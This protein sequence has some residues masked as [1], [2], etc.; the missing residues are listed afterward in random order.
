MQFPKLTQLQSRFAACLGA[1]F[2]VVAIYLLF[3]SPRFADAA[4][5]GFAGDGWRTGQEELWQRDDETED[6]EVDAL[7]LE[8][9]RRSPN[10]GDSEGDGAREEREVEDGTISSSRMVHERATPSPVATALP[11]NNIPCQPQHRSRRVSV[12]G[13]PEC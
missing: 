9:I 1:S 2:T 12:M 13:H 7:G 11:G 4:E 8:P 6:T 3:W 5:I 10:A